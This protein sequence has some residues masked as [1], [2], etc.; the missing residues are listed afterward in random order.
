MQN[1]PHTQN[2]LCFA[3]ITTAA[4]KW[5]GLGGEA[6]S[7]IRHHAPRKCLWNLPSV[8]NFTLQGQSCEQLRA[9]NSHFHNSFLTPQTPFYGFCFF[10]FCHLLKIRMLGSF[11]VSGLLLLY[12]SF[13]FRDFTNLRDIVLFCLLT[14]CKA[15]SGW[16]AFLKNQN[17]SLAYPAFIIPSPATF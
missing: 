10:P 13:N 1:A 16:V 4:C 8:A 11:K 5:A 6:L 2:Y 14:F 17:E 9:Q 3:W 12:H 15:F 7:Q